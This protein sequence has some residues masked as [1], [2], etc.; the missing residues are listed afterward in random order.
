MAPIVKYRHIVPQA[1][2]KWLNRSICRLGCGLE[3]AKRCTSSIVFA[4]WRQCALMGGHFAVICR[5]TLNHPSVAAMRL[6]ANYFDHL[7][8]LDLPTYKVT[9][10]A[11]CFEPTTALWAFRTIQPSSFCCVG[12]S[13]ARRLAA[14]EEHILCG[15][16]RV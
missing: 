3:S 6:M 8:S 1:V 14:C 5:I 9:Q 4:R 10:T 13:L 7:L 15:V 12:F 2:Q 11:K 16:W